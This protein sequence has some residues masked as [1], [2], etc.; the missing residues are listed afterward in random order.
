MTSEKIA[1]Y[2]QI[3]ACFFG[4]PKSRRTIELRHTKW[5]GRGFYLRDHQW[6]HVC[7]SLLVLFERWTRAI[8]NGLL[9]MNLRDNSILIGTFGMNASDPKW[10]TGNGL[11]AIKIAVSPFI[12]KVHERKHSCESLI[13]G[14]LSNELFM[15]RFTVFECKVCKRF[16]SKAMP[17]I[18][19]IWIHFIRHV[20][21][22]VFV[23]V[24]ASE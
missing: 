7:I 20:L 23:C 13:F 5:P 21:W 8:H 14:M 16:Y 22:C 18:T 1:N 19:I 15:N 9:I 6:T 17:R 24:C 12:A 2:Q 10:F 3:E 4:K 11:R